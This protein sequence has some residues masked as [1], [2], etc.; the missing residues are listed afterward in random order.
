M[1]IMA[2]VAAE[3][4][5]SNSIL[6]QIYQ[7]FLQIGAGTNVADITYSPGSATTYPITTDLI[8]KNITIGSNAT[9][10][11]SGTGLKVLVADT[12][13][14]NGIVDV[15][16]VGGRR[17]NTPAGYGGGGGGT[18]VAIARQITGTGTIRANGE[19]GGVG[20][21]SIA[22]WNASGD[23][24]PSFFAGNPLSSPAT[25]GQVGNT[26]SNGGVRTDAY[27][28]NA[29]FP[30]WLLNALM[31]GVR[32]HGY[33]SDGRND[34]SSLG[35]NFVGGGGAAGS[36]SQ[37]GSARRANGG[38]GG[39]N[40]IATGGQGS[41][42]SADDGAGGGGGGAGGYIYILSESP[43]PAL[44]LHARGGNG[45]NGA[46]TLNS[47]AGGGGAGGLIGLLAPS[48]SAT[49]SVT[50]GAK[51]VGFG[52]GEGTRPATAGENGLA[53]HIAFGG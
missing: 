22:S 14:L 43:I 7:T 27:R 37:S 53:Y 49:T 39:G 52:N 25:G 9:L 18:I 44:T 29:M 45:G 15:S 48:T 40:V 5:K 51:G 38:G 34:P 12:L 46:A 20:S 16:N 32:P 3:E 41:Y 13:T 19:E 30:A 47:G 21:T 24:D 1:D 6:S 28:L 36:Y 2:L 50:G 11:F 4:A 33:S 23:G 10:T 8:A 31:F 26:G 17:T 35:V 42:A